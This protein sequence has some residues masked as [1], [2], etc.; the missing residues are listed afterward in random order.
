MGVNAAGA[1]GW[2]PTTLVVPK[3]KKFGALNYPEPLGQS[4]RPVVGETFTIT[5]SLCRS[6]SLLRRLKHLKL[7]GHS[8]SVYVE[9]VAFED[10]DLQSWVTP[11]S[12]PL[13]TIETSKRGPFII[14]H[15]HSSDK[16]SESTYKSLHKSCYR[17]THNTKVN[18]NA[19]A[20]SDYYSWNIMLVI[21][22]QYQC[23]LFPFHDSFL[24]AGSADPFSENITCIATTIQACM[25]LTLLLPTFRN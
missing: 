9:A 12:S 6:V 19:N 5:C 11:F 1:W 13:S 7:F 10:P 18:R 2:R 22:K 23:D 14:L 24:C 16:P 8:I 25:R 15:V 17:Y 21:C 4:R 20:A 3:V